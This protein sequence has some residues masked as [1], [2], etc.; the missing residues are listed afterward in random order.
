MLARVK[1][2][3]EEGTEVRIFTARVSSVGAT[4]LE[5]ALRRQDDIKQARVAIEAWCLEH[6][7]C[8]LPITCCKDYSTI[9]IID[10]IAVQIIPGTGERVDGAD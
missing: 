2:W 8:V 4:T 7:G 5:D 6:L 9:A 1:Q 3:L 10:D